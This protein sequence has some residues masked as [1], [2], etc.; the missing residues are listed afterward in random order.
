VILAA[1]VGAAIGL[2][3]V[4]RAARELL[5]PGPV[6]DRRWNNSN[7]INGLGDRI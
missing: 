2:Q 3:A 5:G 1:G 4:L 7:E 6:G